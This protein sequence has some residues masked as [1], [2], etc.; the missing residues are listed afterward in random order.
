MSRS[1]VRILY[2][3][4]TY[5]CESESEYNNIGTYIEKRAMFHGFVYQDNILTVLSFNIRK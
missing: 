2:T 4:Y 5:E 3:T 1:N